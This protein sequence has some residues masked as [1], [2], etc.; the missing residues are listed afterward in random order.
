MLLS[1]QNLVPPE[2]LAG[3]RS[4]LATGR[5]EPGV[6]SAV[7]SAARVKHNLQL[8]VQSEAAVKANRILLPLLRASRPFQSATYMAAMMA[9]AFCRYEAGMHYGDHIDS[10]IMGT[11]PMLRTDISVT[12]CL[13]DAADYDGGELVI[14]VAGAAQRWKGKAGDAV[15]YPS[16]T[17]HRVEPVTR[18]MR[19]VAI[20]WIQSLVRDWSKRRILFDLAQTI[21]E[22]DRAT[23]PLAHAETLRRSHMNLLRLWAEMPNTNPP[24]GGG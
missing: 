8:P 5:F 11:S 24:P 13:A 17:L 14:D 19:L 21:D 4:A 10:P 22:V 3:I 20:F 9:P 2:E 23:P 16:D 7:G 18:G 12:I 6:G 15:L 1:I